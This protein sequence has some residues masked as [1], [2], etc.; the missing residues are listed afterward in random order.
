MSEE[1]S[2]IDLRSAEEQ[3]PSGPLASSGTGVFVGGRE[4]S[5]REVAALDAR[6]DLVRAGGGVAAIS[7]DS[8]EEVEGR[9]RELLAGRGVPD[10]PD[11]KSWE[12][13]MEKWGFAWVPADVL[14][15]TIGPMETIPSQLGPGAGH[16]AFGRVIGNAHLWWI[17]PHAE[18][19]WRSDSGKRRP[20]RELLR[21]LEMAFTPSDLV[22]D[23]KTPEAFD[24][25]AEG[26]VREGKIA[27][28]R[29]RAMLETRVSRGRR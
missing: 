7:P 6:I 1:Q 19:Q 14:N 15:R 4:L 29:D 13:V 10:A 11:F 22:L 3:A 28:A 17:K 26:R 25:W 2:Q 20:P 27:R 5:E 16:D 8:P 24:R 23:Y 12:K 21:G 9:E 18:G